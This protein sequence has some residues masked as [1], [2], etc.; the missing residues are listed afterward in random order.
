MDGV[1]CFGPPAHGQATYT[2][3]KTWLR[4]DGQEV[5]EPTMELARRYLAAYAPATAS[6]FQSWSGLSAA[7]ARQAFADLEAELLP[8]EVAGVPMWLPRDHADACMAQAAG[9]PAVRM[10]GAFDTYLLGYRTRDLDVPSVLL[11]RVHPGGGIIR[12]VILV[13]GRAVATWSRRQTKDRIRIAVVPFAAL[14]ASVQAAIIAETEDIG[15]FLGKE[16]IC[17][18]VPP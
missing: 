9:A 1:I 14:A 11:K 13:E 17:D 5:A 18:M 3:L 10:L 7:Q 2:L 4:A 16:A 8:V 6:D 12:P 15:R